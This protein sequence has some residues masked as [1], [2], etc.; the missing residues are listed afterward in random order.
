[1]REHGAESVRIQVAQNGIDRSGS[2]YSREFE[3]KVIGA[4]HAAR[5]AGLT[6]II[7]IQNEEQTGEQQKEAEL[8][9][10]ATERVWCALAPVFAHDRGVLFELFNEPRIRPMPPRGPSPD[11]WQTWAAAMNRMISVIPLAWRG[12]RRHCRRAA[13]CGNTAWRPQAVRPCATG[14]VRRSSL[15]TQ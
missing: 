9:T 7:S 5:Q 10:T 3:V 12:Q 8:P 6:V 2:Y 15:C 14:C 13:A 1:M 11:Q 4:V